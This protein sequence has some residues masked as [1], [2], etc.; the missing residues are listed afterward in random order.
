MPMKGNLPMI[1]EEG[2]GLAE[3]MIT[4]HQPARIDKLMFSIVIRVCFVYGFCLVWN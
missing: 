4:V 3:K 2:V 1:A